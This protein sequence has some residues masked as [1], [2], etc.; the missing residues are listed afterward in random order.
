MSHSVA[1]ALAPVQSTAFS[2]EEV[3]RF[4]SDGFIIARGLADPATCSRLRAVISDHLAREVAPAEYEAQLHYPGAP[5]SMDAPGGHTIRRLLQ[6]YGRAAVFR[7]WATSPLLARRLRQLI[8]SR[9]MLAQAHH[10]CV[11]T[12]QPSYSSLTGWHQDIRY[13]SFERP[14]LISVWVALGREHVENGCL[15]VLPGSHKLDLTAERLDQA[16]FLRADQPDNRGLITTCITPLLEPGDVVFFH[17]RTFH[18]ADANHT[19][20]TK[21]SLVF[22]YHAADNRPL[23]GTRSASLPAVLLTESERQE[24][25][26]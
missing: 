5:E 25:G 21:L 2:P 19:G 12:K 10:N 1:M 3:R 23:P 9:V 17:C 14:E 16:L 13:W 20:Q 8:G 18:A 22:T 7:E 6:A 26:S 11:M 15:L 24:A 4:R